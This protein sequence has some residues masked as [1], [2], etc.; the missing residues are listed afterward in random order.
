MRM[1]RK[2]RNTRPPSMGKAGSRL[3]TASVRL[4]TNRYTYAATKPRDR[5]RFENSPAEKTLPTSKKSGAAASIN[6]PNTTLE[7]GPT[8]EMMSSLR[9]SWGISSMDD[10]PPM[11]RRVIFLT[12]MP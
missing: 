9:G 2:A 10:T 8:T 6:S 3:N 11:G 4:T 7:R 1:A 12:S 5:S